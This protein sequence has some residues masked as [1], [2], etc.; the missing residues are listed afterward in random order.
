MK[1]LSST[2]AFRL[3]AFGFSVLVLSA[4]QSIPVVN[5]ADL[6]TA[7]QRPDVAGLSEKTDNPSSRS[8]SKELVEPTVTIYE[9]NN[10]WDRMQA[11][12]QLSYAYGHPA[13]A[14]QIIEYA[15]NQPLFDLIAERSSPF[16]YWIVAEIEDRGLPMELALVPFVES[17]F[18]PNAYSSEHAVGLWQFIG[19]TAESFGLQ[20]DWWYDARRDPRASTLAA[21]DYLQELHQQFDADWLLALA[22]YNTGEGNVRRAIRRSGSSPEDADFWTLSLAGETRS[23]VPRILALAKIIS[24]SDEFGIEL[25]QIDNEEPLAVVEV[26]GQIDMA[27]AARLAQLDDEVLKSL[28]PGYLQWATHPD[29]PQSLAVPIEHAEFLVA[30]LSTMNRADLVT[31]DRYEISPGDTLGAIARKLD[32][33]V[34]VL[35]VVNQLA[36][37]RIIAGES[38]LI[39]RTDAV[40]SLA[41]VPIIRPARSMV[42]SVPASYTVRR[43][44]NLWTIA[45]RF[46][47]RSQDIANKNSIEIDS[48]LHSGQVLDLRFAQTSTHA[49]SASNTDGSTGIY[50]V[51]PGDTM[52]SIA[53][54]FDTSLQELL[55]WNSISS[56]DLIY[57]GQ[58]IVISPPD[59]RLN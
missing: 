44:D 35:Q 18:N 47:I 27:Q 23:H 29:S 36:G 3:S 11:G 26:G 12:F 41:A 4:C 49:T 16:L 43:G 42:D 56:R 19:P 46:D 5:P 8:D 38:L 54:R 31:W 28:N 58:E 15:E 21:L 17:T 48:L 20:Q 32:T 45:R 25:H 6:S 50:I 51:R 1:L 2:S 14:N 53:N 22:A 37:S 24:Q 10:V 57:P 9:F 55:I 13:V 34:D 30:G 59:S 40:G 33:R 7:T 39:P 52:A